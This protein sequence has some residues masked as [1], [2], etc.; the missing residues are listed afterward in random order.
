VLIGNADDALG[1]FEAVGWISH[2]D[3][4]YR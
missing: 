3:S 2:I 1:S 4:T